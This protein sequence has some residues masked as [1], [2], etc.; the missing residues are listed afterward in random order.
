[1]LHFEVQEALEIHRDPIGHY[2]HWSIAVGVLSS[3]TLSTGDC[4]SL[5][6]S[7]GSPCSGFI[8]G[9]EAFRKILGP[10][11]RAED[12]TGAVIGVG[13]RSPAPPGAIVTAGPLHRIEID[14]HRDNVLTILRD[15]PERLFH[16]RGAHAP[17]LWCGECP[18]VLYNQPAA[19]PILQHLA[20]HHPD[21]ALVTQ[22][23][24]VL[25]HLAKTS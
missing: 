25:D 16:N 11:V 2:H 7:D 17:W 3:G 1:M 15:H 10:T 6:T 14:T 21:A 18:R 13:V 12:L 24:R 9:F 5:P 22:V 19:Q 4:V 8:F 23:R 20:A